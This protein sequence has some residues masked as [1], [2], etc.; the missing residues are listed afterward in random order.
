MTVGWQLGNGVSTSCSSS[1]RGGV[2]VNVVCWKLPTWLD[3]S[4]MLIF[5]GYLYRGVRNRLAVE[6][7]CA[8]TQIAAFTAFT[9]FIFRFSVAERL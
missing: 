9:L 7:Q 1:L 8:Q 3:N 2:R 5:Q 4:W 6:V